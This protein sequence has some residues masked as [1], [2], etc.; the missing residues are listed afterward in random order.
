MRFF[1][2]REH[3]AVRRRIEIEADHVAQLG[4][5]RRIGG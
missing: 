4:R 5:E 1:V 2:D 3:E